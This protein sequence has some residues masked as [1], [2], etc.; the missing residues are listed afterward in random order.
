ML[1]GSFS[2]HKTAAS[3]KV[4][5]NFCLSS[6]EQV[7]TEKYWWPWFSS[8]SMSSCRNSSCAEI[9]FSR[10]SFVLWHTP[11]TV[12]QITPYVT[13]F[14]CCLLVTGVSE[15]CVLGVLYKFTDWYIQLI[16]VHHM[17]NSTE[18]VSIKCCWFR[19]IKRI[20]PPHN[21][22]SSLG[23]LQNNSLVKKWSPC[24]KTD[25]GFQDGRAHKNNGH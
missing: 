15:N 8:M 23:Q 2:T 13:A 6:T 9:S 4:S 14:Q 22:K 16:N 3:N 20:Q 19:D 17:L 1:P 12:V 24:V 11:V 21:A 5:S 25:L 10:R 7:E 18:T